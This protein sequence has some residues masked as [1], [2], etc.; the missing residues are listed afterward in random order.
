MTEIIAEIIHKIDNECSIC[1]EQLTLYPTNKLKC[2]HIFH[3]QCINTWFHT[4]NSCPFCRKQNKTNFVMV[5][6]EERLAWD[7]TNRRMI[8]LNIQMIELNRVMSKY[9]ID[10]KYLI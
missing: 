4:N 6:P 5:T 9:R 2:N 3:T 7:E 8:E 10:K 1:L